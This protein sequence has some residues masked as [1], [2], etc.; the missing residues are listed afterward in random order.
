MKIYSSNL[1]ISACSTASLGVLSCL[2]LF[3]FNLLRGYCTTR[4]LRLLLDHLSGYLHTGPEK[5]SLVIGQIRSLWRVPPA[6]SWILNIKNSW[7]EH[8]LRKLHRKCYNLG[9]FSM[10]SEQS[11]FQNVNLWMHKQIERE[12][13]LICRVLLVLFS[14]SLSKRSARSRWEE[15]EWSPGSQVRQWN[16]SLPGELIP[17]PHPKTMTLLTTS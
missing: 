9:L 8:R 10:T 6:K 7:K 11:Q 15:Q 13:S 16:S 4:G 3:S 5:K 14:S 1:W 17:V 2:F 12:Y